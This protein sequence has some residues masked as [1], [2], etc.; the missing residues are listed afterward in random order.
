MMS[1]FRYSLFAFRCSLFGTNPYAL[2]SGPW[3][4]PLPP[5]SH[6][7]L[8]TKSCRKKI[9]AKYCI[10]GVYKQNLEPQRLTALDR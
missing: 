7:I 10:Q 2:T 3:G 6:K 9:L 5:L 1:A 8:K 4:T